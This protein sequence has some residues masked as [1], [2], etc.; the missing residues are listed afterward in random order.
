VAATEKAPLL[1]LFLKLD[2]KLAREILD[3]EEFK[4]RTGQSQVPASPIGRTRSDLLQPCIRLLDLLD[5]PAEIPF[6]SDLIQREIVY[7]LLHNPQ[8]DRLRNR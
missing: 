4:P 6:F 1:A 2:M 5:A 7:R 8:G 3:R